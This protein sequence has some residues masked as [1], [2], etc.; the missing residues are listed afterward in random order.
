[1]GSDGPKAND[2]MTEVVATF[3]MSAL[4]QKRT[5]IH[6]IFGPRAFILKNESTTF[7][8][9]NIFP[10]PVINIVLYCFSKTTD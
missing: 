9:F 2:R 5:S 10:T 8:I 4:G 7:V 3:L 1:M 6:S